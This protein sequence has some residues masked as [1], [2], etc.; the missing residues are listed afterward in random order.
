MT[1]R[2]DNYI[3]ALGAN[4][5]TRFYDPL[6]RLTTKEFTFKRA[7]ITQAKLSDN[8]TILDLAC[9]TGTLSIEIKR[10]FPKVKISAIDGDE[11]ILEI[12]RRKA[13]DHRVQ[14]DT[15][16]AFSDSLPFSD[17][18]FDRVFSTLFF[19]HIT[20]EKKSATLREIVR[21]LKPKGEFHIADYGKPTNLSQKTLSNVIR[22]I[23]GHETTKDN[24]AGR[25]RGLIEESGFLTVERTKSFNTMLGTI[26][27]FRAIMP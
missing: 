18:S 9:G 1:R 10:R 5:A 23:D 13:T 20:L 11:K 3:P 21:V 17:N 14:I 24:F 2:E 25:L 15:R 6:V 26:R 16:K 7:L 27:L 12:A 8:Q 4:W 22:M 19:H